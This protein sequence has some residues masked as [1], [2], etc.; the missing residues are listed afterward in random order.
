M[1][2]CGGWCCGHACWIYSKMNI[3][4][5][6][7]LLVCLFSIAT[8]SADQNDDDQYQVIQFNVNQDCSTSQ[9]RYG[10]ASNWVGGQVPNSPKQMAL[11]DFT[12]QPSNAG[13]ILIE[14]DLAVGAINLTS[15]ST[16]PAVLSVLVVIPEIISIKV[17][18]ITLGSSQLVLSAGV[19]ASIVTLNVN[20]LESGVH[21]GQGSFLTVDTA[22]FHQSNITL[23]TNAN[24]EVLNEGLSMIDCTVYADVYSQLEITGTQP[25]NLTNVQATIMGDLTVL[26]HLVVQSSLLQL[27]SLESSLGWLTISYSTVETQGNVT[28]EQGVE[29]YASNWMSAYDPNNN[30][31]TTPT[32]VFINHMETQGG[33]VVVLDQLYA[34]VF[35]SSDFTGHLVASACT[36]VVLNHCYVQVFTF[37]GVVPTTL[38]SYNSIISNMNGDNATAPTHI[39]YQ[40]Y[41]ELHSANSMSFSQLGLVLL[42]AST[43][44]LTGGIVEIEGGYSYIA[45]TDDST[46]AAT[47]IDLTTTLIVSEASNSTIILQ[48]GVVTASKII[49]SNTNVQLGGLQINGD[50]TITSCNVT[51][52][53]N[54]HINGSYFADTTSQFNILYPYTLPTSIYGPI[55]TVSDA[56]LANT[57]SF[58]L[59][60]NSDSGSIPII[61]VNTPYYLLSSSQPLTTYSLSFTTPTF[62]SLSP[63]FQTAQIVSVLTIIG[64]VSAQNYQVVRFDASKDCSQQECSYFDATNW[65]GG[66]VPQS[67]NQAAV[68]DYSLQ[69]GNA[70]TITIEGNLA[71]GSINVSSH[72]S[73]LPAYLVI[74]AVVKTDSIN[75][76]AAQLI[77][78]V[79]SISVGSLTSTQGSTILV[80]PGAILNAEIANIQESNI[81]ISENGNFL[82]TGASAYIA[83]STLGADEYSYFEL[84]ATTSNLVRVNQD[85]V[86]KSFL[87][88]SGSIIFTTCDLAFS[89]IS[90]AGTLTLASQ[91]TIST[92]SNSSVTGTLLI[93]QYSSYTATNQGDM[94][95]V[96]LA[97]IKVQPGATLLLTDVYY[98]EIDNGVLTGR[99]T[100]D[101]CS[102]VDFK[103]SQVQ[104]LVV[105]NAPPS[106]FYVQDTI[107]LNVD[108]SQ[109]SGPQVYMEFVGYTE[110]HGLQTQAA[111]V[112]NFVVSNSSTLRLTGTYPITAAGLQ[113]YILV[114]DNGTLIAN[115]IN[116]QTTQII[117]NPKINQ[118]SITLGEGIASSNVVLQN[119]NLQVGGIQING[120]LSVSNTSITAFDNVRLNGSVQGIQGSQLAILYPYDLPTSS[121]S[122]IFTVSGSIVVDYIA[123]GLAKNP[124]GFTPS[125]VSGS[126]YYLYSSPQP[127]TTT[128]QFTTPSVTTLKPTFR[129]IQAYKI[130]YLTV[131]FN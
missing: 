122:T 74:S 27:Y 80:G 8:I 62:T 2:K 28:V 60:P 78:D 43:L 31:T 127:I 61:T 83:D 24:F 103:Q 5:L 11:I 53:D 124:A 75:L 56:F 47:N 92:Y 79:S 101:S 114:Q 36:N 110:V 41:N 21:I 57:F 6:L 3:R 19:I 76:S 54:L 77:A 67:P 51:I 32:I 13:T 94:I 69:P 99:V 121:Y 66:I 68:I 7:L 100:V 84:S 63:I 10:D 130:N 81:T 18:T 4:V 59:S 45:L 85:Y 108:A 40:G 26:G 65:I 16:A 105:L 104:N 96:H 30:T 39:A 115:D 112:V 109:I 52:S 23:Q 131:T 58:G 37:E 33:S 88:A 128:C 113:S 89:R 38:S 129:I 111:S 42:N 70:G 64:L 46:L 9:C 91:S 29:L 82:V 25:S 95:F 102:F 48:D 117:T 90:V 1:D 123:F 49:L 86:S 12:S 116:L 35:N 118:A 106:N 73:V 87:I 17:E 15:T 72:A 97:N 50:L 98:T 107:I 14:S 93:T 120:N 71:V 125:I 119:T 22:S 44:N 20:G 34:A 55:V 126:V